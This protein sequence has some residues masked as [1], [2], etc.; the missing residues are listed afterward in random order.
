M[1]LVKKFEESQLP[2]AR[3]PSKRAAADPRLRPRG[4]WNRQRC[5]YSLV[6]IILISVFAEKF[7]KP[8]KSSYIIALLHFKYRIQDSP[9]WRNDSDSR[10]AKFFPKIRPIQLILY[11]LFVTFRSSNLLYF[12]HSSLYAWTFT[13][14]LT[15]IFLVLLHIFL[16]IIKGSRFWPQGQGDRWV[17]NFLKYHIFI[18]ALR[19]LTGP[20]SR[21]ISAKPWEK[22]LLLRK[23]VPNCT[24]VGLYEIT[25]CYPE[26]LCPL[27]PAVTRRL[28][29]SPV[30]S[31]LYICENLPDAIKSWQLLFFFSD[32]GVV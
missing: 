14:L 21:E 4:H 3:N 17:E 23:S 11:T 16:L 13:M 2:G 31:W 1:P 30:V 6:N 15:C 7:R 26:S 22:S 20:V 18:W 29:C 10:L 27:R 25:S 9:K 5:G 8:Q 19:K 12:L 28:P 24:C 32:C